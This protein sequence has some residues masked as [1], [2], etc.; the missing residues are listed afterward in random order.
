MTTGVATKRVSDVATWVKRQFGDESGVQI[1]DSD[2]I[3]W[4]NQ[5]QA[6]IAFLADPIQAIS[7]SVLVPGTYTYPLPVETATKIISLRVDGNPIQS[8]EFQEAEL[9]LQKEDPQHTSTGRPRYWYKFANQLYLWPTPDTAWS[10]DIFY[11]KDPA[12]ITGTAD[13]LNLPDKYFEPI[14]QFV[15]AKA[16]ELDEEFESSKTAMQAFNDRLGRTV[17]EDNTTSVAFY[18]KLTFVDY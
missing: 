9:R 17:E 11:F 5:A 15:M 10:I 1:T 7:S 2:I 6:E 12:D 13:L 16:Y 4:I 8:I 14:V 3:R 18:P